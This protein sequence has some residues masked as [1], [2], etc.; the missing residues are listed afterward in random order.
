MVAA[1]KVIG[2]EMAAEVVVDIKIIIMPEITI[3]EVHLIRDPPIIKGTRTIK[4]IHII[5]RAIVTINSH[6]NHNRRPIN[7]LRMHIFN[8]KMPIT[9][10][11][12]NIINKMILIIAKPIKDAVEEYKVVGQ[13]E[14]IVS[15]NKIFL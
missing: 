9:I 2:V 13:T 12:H 5:N 14:V 3:K 11:K 7:Y 10:R 4:I 15:F 8:L 6:N 1:I